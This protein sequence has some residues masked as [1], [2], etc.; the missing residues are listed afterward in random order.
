MVI[1]S[2]NPGWEEL[3]TS[4]SVEVFDRE[5]SITLLRRRAPRL[6]ESEAGR[7]AEAL[8]DLPLALAQ[9]GAHLAETA[10][11]VED[12]LTL[13]GERTT[14]LLARDAPVSYP[15]SLAASVQI[16]LERLGAQCPAALVLLT[17]AGW[18]APEPIPWSLFSAHP[19]QLPEPLARVAGD[20]LAFAELIRLVRRHGLARVEPTTLA[21]ASA[22]LRDPARP[23]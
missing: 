12:Y 16:A 22:A 5:E 19:A 1:T 23:A 13:L 2:R 8:G 11:S 17:L 21:V 7:V 15:V 20:R 10:T 4:V 18:L 6:T 3:A 14:E 9:A